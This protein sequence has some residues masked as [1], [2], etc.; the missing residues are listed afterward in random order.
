LPQTAAEILDTEGSNSV[1]DNV[2]FAKVFGQIFDSS[3]AEDYNCRRMFMDLLVLADPTGAVDM[4]YE[5]IARRTNVPLEEV[6]RYINELCQP[7]AASRSQLHEGKR[8][9]ALDSNRDWGWQIVNYHHYRKLRDQEALRAYFRDAQR[10]YRRKKKAV[11]DNGLTGLTEFDNLSR[12]LTSPSYS[13]HISSGS[14]ILSRCTLEESISYC[15]ERGLTKEDGEWFFDK[16]VGCGWTNNKQPIKDWKATVRA[17]EKI[18]IF[19]SQKQQSKQQ[20]LSLIPECLKMPNPRDW[21]EAKRIVRH[22]QA[23]RSEHPAYQKQI[24]D[25]IEALT[26]QFKLTP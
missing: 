9:I 3:I 1:F 14:K 13:Q 4:T 26:S 2:M 23:K 6:R 7:D 21:Q 17:W 18:R 10:E 11:K 24:D 20:Q 19:P 22:L 25:R 16:C 8:L 15:T 5:A 12:S